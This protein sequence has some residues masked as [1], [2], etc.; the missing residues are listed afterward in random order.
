MT[1]R[2]TITKNDW[3]TGFQDGRAGQ[4]MMPGAV[5]DR[6]SYVSGWIEGRA[7]LQKRLQE[8]TTPE[9]TRV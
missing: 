5:H 9:G 8:L 3:E 2:I 4:P 6:F 1:P 7:L